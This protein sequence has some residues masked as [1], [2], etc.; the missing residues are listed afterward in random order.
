[1]AVA[2]ADNQRNNV[3]AW[4]KAGFIEN[5]GS[6]TD[7]HLLISIADRFQKMVNIEQRKQS[8]ETGRRMVP[9]NGADRI[10]DFILRSL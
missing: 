7:S 5:A 3:E 1:M 4:E 9:G 6:W 8:S 2:V 10:I